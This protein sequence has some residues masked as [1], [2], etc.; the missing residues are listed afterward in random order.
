MFRHFTDH[1]P[2]AS[3]RVTILFALASLLVNAASGQTPPRDAA[4]ALNPN[5]PV[6]RQ[7]AGGET[8]VFQFALKRGQYA[9]VEVEQRD[10]DVVVSLWGA[11]GAPESEMDAK[12]GYLWRESV[13]AMAEKR[14]ATFQVN[15]RAYG[16]GE[17]VGSYTIKL[18][19]LRPARTQ[20]RQRLEAEQHFYQARKLYLQANP[21]YDGAVKEFG[22][23]LAGWRSLD[24]KY[25]QAVT[26]TNLGWT[27]SDLSQSE[28]AVDYHG[29]ALKLFQE[30]KDRTGEG[31]AAKGMGVAYDDLKQYEKAETYY[32]QALKIRRELN[33]GRG[34]I[35]VLVSLGELYQ[36]LGKNE[37]GLE[38]LL[39]GLASAR[40]L[41]TPDLEAFA[42]AQL[43][44]F[45]I[46]L[47]RFDVAV[48]YME[49][50]LP[51]RQ[52]L[53]DSAREVFLNR[54]IGGLS[55]AALHE[56]GKAKG[57]LERALELD[58]QSNDPA[59]EA[60]DLVYLAN[61]YQGLS[62]FENARSRMDQAVEVAAKLGDR[63]AESDVLNQSGQ[64][65]VNSGD[66]DTG[67]EVLGRALTIKRGLPDD[68]DGESA[69]LKYLSLAY[70]CLGEETKVLEYSEQGLKLDTELHDK[71][72]QINFLNNIA[73]AYSNSG[74]Y[75]KAQAFYEQS[76]KIARDE[77]L[78]K[79]EAISVSQS[80]NLHMVLQQYEKARTLYEEALAAAKDL[81]EPRL[82][83][84]ILSGM[85]R[86]SVELRQYDRARDYL[87]QAL[88]LTRDSG[89]TNAESDALHSLGLL[90]A[91]LHQYD[92]AHGYF[93]QALKIAKGNKNTFKEIYLLGSIGDLFDKQS[94]YA[95]ALEYHRQSLELARTAKN[96]Y[97]ISSQLA[98][99]AFIYTDLSR[100]E[101]AVNCLEESLA[102]SRA[103][104][105]RLN[106]ATALIGLGNVYFQLNQY[107]KARDRYEQGLQLAEGMK[108]RWLV[109]IST[110]SMGAVHADL[111]ENQVAR[112]DYE[113]SLALMKEI[114]N[115]RGEGNTLNAL[116][117]VYLNLKQYDKARTYCEQ[118]LSIAREVK[119]KR[120]EA[121]ALLNLG[122]AFSNL[123]QYDKALDH[124]ERGLA[125]AREVRNRG[126]EGYGLNG[127]GDLYQKSNQF[128]KAD[129]LFQRALGIAREIRSRK[130]EGAVLSNLMELSSKQKTPR[131]AIFYGKQAVNAFQEIRGNLNGFDKDSQRTYLKDK[132]RTYRILTDILVSQGRIAE[133][134]QVL[135]MLKEAELYEY[136]RRDDQVAKEL[137]QSIG[138][139]DPERAAIKRYEE[140]AERI[141]AIGA[142]VDELKKA[143]ASNPD[144][145]FPDQ[146]KLDALQ[147]ELDG[148]DKTFR[149]FLDDLKVKF[150][151]QK[152]ER[153]AQVE[154]GLKSIL[155]ELHADR[156]V[157]VST[158]VGERRL[159]LIVTTTRAQRAHTVEIGEERLNGLI[160]EFHLA[161]TNPRLDP[162]PA[163]QK[164]YDVLVRPL[165]G[166]LAG[167][168]ADSIIWSLDGALR[169]VPPAA[170]WD[171]DRGY[172]V[173]R[174]ANSIITPASI[175]TLLSPA[176]DKAGWRALG[177][178]VSKGG[179]GFSEL[180]AVP[181]ELDCIIGGSADAGAAKTRLCPDGVLA[182]RKLLDENFTQS[183]F[184]GALELYPIIH[185][186]SHF[187]F[188][189]GN[190]RDSFLLLGGGEHRRFTVEQLRSVSLSKAELI[191]LSACNTAKPGGEQ[192]NG[193]EVESFS[194]V[195]QAIGAH[196]V[197]AT[198]WS[199]ADPSTRDFMVK[200]Y[201][202]YAR[203]GMTKIAALRQ[204]QLALLNGDGSAPGGV[205]HPADKTQPQSASALPNAGSVAEPRRDT[206]GPQDAG[207]EEA[208]PY[209]T[210][211][212]RPYA[213]PYYWAP[214]VLFGNWR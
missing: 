73:G 10:I 29:Q 124:Y 151:L 28:K 74:Q 54:T 97:W 92:R 108:H 194:A 1:R 15:V 205:R 181:E 157:I 24:D 195:A 46:R 51:V 56:Y 96:L 103:M 137:L 139:S 175:K 59:G 37:R 7:I 113:K 30:I 45:Y 39:Q 145:P 138:L 67:K 116:G 204:A 98:G 169:Y 43:S 166:D 197:T 170:L 133:A 156:T 78:K 76:V 14:S 85:A 206:V 64:L 9:R 47:R 149:R 75:E 94:R 174:F 36:N 144:A 211:A 201:G 202:F 150:K 183:S 49:Q 48:Q 122:T 213:H 110:S 32:Q 130:L 5:R 160:K 115:R 26:L 42:L 65:Y 159:N 193:V 114:L 142:Q 209:H 44:T 188:Q 22:A 164:L 192:A 127:L 136:L 13:S 88:K 53:K 165:E 3:A 71:V 52:R 38:C 104:K 140:I 173:Q 101:E 147:G 185:I 125:L 112:D 199:V 62:Q 84:L 102:V 111:S 86:A 40:E 161:L 41:K 17:Q 129:D 207:Q 134:E 154:S 172:L 182:G 18:A 132:E 2:P 100:Y 83:D 106:E 20:D 80:A 200:F 155:E 63:K 109:G 178:G 68:K 79:Y 27:Y 77:R 180:P 95:E 120:D 105:N 87:E 107:G 21:D 66:C 171:K 167:V 168:K 176:G 186:A 16:V 81:N 135:A 8:H 208:P 191:T 146:D 196:S 143:R 162:R 11:G 198:L 93:E 119:E 35:V 158:I 91:R 90:H 153:V 179:E 23:A 82:T 60:Q 131:L 72:G 61:V 118:A 50:E 58:K 212:A 203:D 33:D 12:N 210:D 89:N 70:L 4:Q 19:E 152:D 190:D 126:S 117:T 25:R 6:E 163:G 184:T 57:Y 69:V 189:P 55:Y 31:K 141:T 187:K 34:A 99:M 128:D 177:V 214:F 121:D 148:A 123:N